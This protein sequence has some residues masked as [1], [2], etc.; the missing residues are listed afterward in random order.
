[1]IDLLIVDIYFIRSIPQSSSTWNLTWIESQVMGSSVW[2]VRQNWVSF[3]NT[4]VAK[5]LESPLFSVC[6]CVCVCVWERE[7]ER[8]RERVNMVGLLR[9]LVH[10]YEYR[11]IITSIRMIVLDK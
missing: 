4:N 7:R 10:T 2:S 8:E 9:D 3:N 6:V 5:W 11:K 1:M